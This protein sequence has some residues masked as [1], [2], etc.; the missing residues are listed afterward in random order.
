VNRRRTVTAKV[1]V[2]AKPMGIER[3]QVKTGRS[4]RNV[5]SAPPMSRRKGKR[6]RPRV[7][8]SLQLP[9]EGPPKTVEGAHQSREIFRHRLKKMEVDR[10]NRFC[11]NLLT[12]YGLGELTFERLARIL[13][14]VLSKSKIDDE[15]AVIVNDTT[16]RGLAKEDASALIL[17]SMIACALQMSPRVRARGNPGLP[18]F[19]RESSVAMIRPGIGYPISRSGRSFD[20]CPVPS[21]FEL[22]AGFWKGWGIKGVT[23][24]AVEKWYTKR[25]RTTTKK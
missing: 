1:R 13:F 3:Q 10:V 11:E 9:H 4:T 23:P 25:A 20:G 7:A 6:A 16:Y 24:A 12:A 8:P 17:G 15:C 19:V 2:A 22:V 14:D 21:A 5:S 18:M